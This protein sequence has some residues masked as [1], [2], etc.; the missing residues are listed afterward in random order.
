MCP[1]R[2]VTKP[3]VFPDD[4]GH[5]VANWTGSTAALHAKST[6]FLG[7]LNYN[8]W[9]NYNELTVLPHWE[10]WLDCRE[11]SPNGPLIQVSEIL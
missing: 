9:V 3:I 8:T 1:P 2:N 10:S 4:L 5:E 7:S 11:S 6:S